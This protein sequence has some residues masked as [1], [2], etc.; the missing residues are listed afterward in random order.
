MPAQPDKFALVDRFRQVRLIA[1]GEDIPRL[2]ESLGIPVTTW[3][4]YEA[5]VCMPGQIAIAFLGVTGVSP[6][7]LLTGQGRMFPARGGRH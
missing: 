1:F 4:N 5:G 3:T 6:E 7:W 2:A